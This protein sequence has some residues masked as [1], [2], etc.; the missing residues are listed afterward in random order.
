MDFHVPLWDGFPHVLKTQQFSR[1][2]LDALF[3]LADEICL[4]IGDPRAFRADLR[5]LGSGRTLLSLFYEPSSRTEATFLRSAQNLGMQTIAIRDPARTS[6]EVKGES[7]EDT[8]RTYAGPHRSDAY[9]ITDM[10][11][12]R[13]ESEDRPE[14][15]AAVSAVPILN[16]G[17]GSDQH[18]TQS[19]VD[20]YA[21]RKMLGR[22]ADLHVGMVGDLRH[23]RTCRSL[24]YLLGKIGINVRFTFIAHPDLQMGAD[25]CAYLDRH[26]VHYRKQ[27]GYEDILSRLDVLYVTR[28]QKERDREK[29]EALVPEL[30]PLRLTPERLQELRPDARVL[31][32]L[33]VD[34]SV[35][36][37][38]EIAPALCEWARTHEKDPRLAWFDQCDLAIPVRMALLA[39]ILANHK[40]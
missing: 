20:L 10:I 32:P 5:A 13:H 22:F 33:P 7:F 40:A 36:G 3:V 19:L 14:R 9:R 39:V 34:S 2:H 30:A 35:P 28:L 11:V 26:D 38:S 17:N 31:H 1:V 25:V 23:G 21:L 6:S 24:T 16:G 15:A 27:S 29:L 18:P 37:L 4:G 12:L 8:V